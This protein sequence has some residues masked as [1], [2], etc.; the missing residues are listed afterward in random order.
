MLNLEGGTGD[1]GLLSLEDGT[2]NHGLLNLEGGDRGVLSMEDGSRNHGTQFYFV[3][4]EKENEGDVTRQVT[5]SLN[6]P[7]PCSENRS[8]PHGR[9]EWL[10]QPHSGARP[11]GRLR[12]RVVV[13]T[14][15]KHP[16]SNAKLARL[17]VS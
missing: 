17:G 11:T 12:M 2:C 1:N 10:H 13:H 9:A 7:N 15:E 16:T 8:L 3:L 5:H 14:P 6:P 4:R